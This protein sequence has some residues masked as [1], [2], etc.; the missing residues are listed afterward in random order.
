MSA[1]LLILIEEEERNFR[2]LTARRPKGGEMCARLGTEYC[3]TA[4]PH[5]DTYEWIE[6]CDSGRVSV[7]DAE[8]SG[9]PSTLSGDIKQQEAVAII[10]EATT[11]EIASHLC[12]SYSECMTILGAAQFSQERRANCRRT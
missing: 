2:P 7:I 9:R 1:R 6:I 12:S 10:T 3:E 5:Q 11:E 4:I 8:C